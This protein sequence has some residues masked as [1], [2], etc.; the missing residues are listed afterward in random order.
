M[1]SYLDRL[2]SELRD[3]LIVVGR[4]ARGLFGIAYT[5]RIFDEN[6]ELFEGLYLAG[7]SHLIVS[8]MLYDVGV[9]RNDGSP[10]PVGTVSSAISRARLRAAVRADVTAAAAGVRSI[11]AVPGGSL[12]AVAD[13]GMLLQRPAGLGNTLPRTAGN[14]VASGV[15]TAARDG[16]VAHAGPVKSA[17]PAQALKVRNTNSADSALT[18]PRRTPP[19]PAARNAAN[20]LNQLRSRPHGETN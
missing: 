11:A 7:A 19:D 4:G 9:R 5:Q 3:I 18:E 1:T 14:G 8:Q 17:P 12:Q 20:I 15:D 10:L 2:S 16:A 13:C 6:L